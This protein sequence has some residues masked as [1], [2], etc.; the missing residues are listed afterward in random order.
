MEQRRIR[1]RTVFLLSHRSSSRR[2]RSSCRCASCLH[3][4]SLFLLRAA[5]LRAC[6]WAR[7]PRAARA[8]QQQHTNPLPHAAVAA[9]LAFFALRPGKGWL[10]RKPQPGTLEDGCSDSKESPVPCGVDDCSASAAQHSQQD[11]SRRPD[12]SDAPTA[13]PLTA[14]LELLPAAPVAAAVAGSST[15]LDTLLPSSSSQQGQ[16]T[17]L[18]TFLP[19][20]RASGDSTAY[21]IDT[22]LPLTRAAGAPPVN[23][24]LQ[25]PT[26][27]AAALP[28][29]IYEQ[30]AASEVPIGGHQPGPQP[31]PPSYLSSAGT[32][33]AGGSAQQLAAVAPAAVL[34]AEVSSSPS[35]RCAL[36][37]GVLFFRVQ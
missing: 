15:E 13:T 7:M 24:A 22:L 14:A 34:A 17:S 25:A 33:W 4:T 10:R 2:R 19:S 36:A 31:L 27:P 26:A 11:G 18:D 20:S 12:I 23:S 28:S 16:A 35:S 3:T 1:I 37:G 6:C 5:L 30:P 8:S 29:H 21:G 32:D 9:V